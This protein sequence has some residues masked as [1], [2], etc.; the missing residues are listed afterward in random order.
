MICETSDFQNFSKNKKTYGG[1]VM[2][3]SNREV[4]ANLNSIGVFMDFEKKHGKALL[5]ATG[6]LA[7]I[8]NRRNLVKAYEP[9]EEAVKTVGDN[10]DEI[11]E[12]LDAQVE[13]DEFSKI[14]SG[15]FKDGITSLG[16]L[17][18]EFMTE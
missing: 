16:I 2:K 11:N 3:I 1:M 4:I 10:K 17:A 7:V 15:D 8:T 5:S 13:I 9:Y 18:L 12:L 14:T 6:E